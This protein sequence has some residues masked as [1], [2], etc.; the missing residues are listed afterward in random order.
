MGA[1]DSGRQGAGQGGFASARGV[2]EQQVPLSQHGGDS[3]ANYLLFAQQCLP[4][5]KHH[6]VK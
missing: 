4:Y 5:V 6:F 2:F 1:L 3:Q